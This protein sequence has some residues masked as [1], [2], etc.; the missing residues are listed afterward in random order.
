MIHETLLCHSRASGN[1]SLGLYAPWVLVKTGMMLEGLK[2][3]DYSSKFQA[4]NFNRVES[5][6]NL[7]CAECLLPIAL[8]PYP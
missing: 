2:L 5:Q 8:L 6:L 1:P 3:C 4:L 7:N